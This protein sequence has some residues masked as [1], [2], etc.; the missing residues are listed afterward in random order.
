MP[1]TDVSWEISLDGRLRVTW[2]SRV[3]AFA[4][5][6]A[7]HLSWMTEKESGNSSGTVRMTEVESLRLGQAYNITLVE[8]EVGNTSTTFNFVACK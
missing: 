1:E 4:E 2:L 6:D 7:V 5:D 8:T 3:S